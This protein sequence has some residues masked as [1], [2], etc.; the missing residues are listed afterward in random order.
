MPPRIATTLERLRQDLADCLAPD[1][2]RAACRV[3]GHRWRDRVLDPVTT[4]YL[5]LLQVLHGNT[6]CQHAVHFGRWD[7]TDSAYCAARKRLPLGALRRLAGWVA[8]RVRAS[9]SAA[10]SWHGHRV[11]LLDG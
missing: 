9:V 5:F 11:W 3:A 10:S 6:A 2:I 7:F 1:A 4:V 8:Q